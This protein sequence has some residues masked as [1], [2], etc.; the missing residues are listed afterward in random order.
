V[1]HFSLNAGETQAAN[2][3]PAFSIEGAQA[4][5][6]RSAK[7]FVFVPVKKAVSAEPQAVEFADLIFA[8]F[9]SFGWFFD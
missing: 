1:Q 4:F 2:A 5:L 8:V 3:V 9:A 6:R 7:S